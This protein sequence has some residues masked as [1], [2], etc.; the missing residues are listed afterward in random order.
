MA[1][2]LLCLS[3]PMQSWGWRATSP[4]LRDTAMEPTKSGVIGLLA[5]ALGRDR[6]ADISDLQALRF[7]VRTDCPGRLMRDYQ[8]IWIGET[9]DQKTGMKKNT[10]EPTERFYLADAKFLAA[11]ESDDVAFLEQLE[12]ALKHPK[13]PLF[14]GR[15]SYVPDRPVWCKN[16]LL[17]NTDLLSALK[18]A[19]WLCDG[20]QNPHNW[21]PKL[22]I[23]VDAGMGSIGYPQKDLPISFDPKHRRMTWRDV[24]VEEVDLAKI[25]SSSENT[26]LKS[27][28]DLDQYYA[29]T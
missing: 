20:E 12:W 3:G 6:T 27:D 28:T 17:Q 24:R 2:L 8:I 11:V 9:T 18:S 22:R 16:G 21:Y 10:L 23:C 14:L 4:K 15:R 13:Y 26:N 19:R 1:V 29:F 5:A 25:R 7:G